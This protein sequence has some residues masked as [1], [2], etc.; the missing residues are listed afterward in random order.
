MLNKNFETQRKRAAQDESN[1]QEV[2]K[3]VDLMKDSVDRKIRGVF[4]Q[5]DNPMFKHISI[6]NAIQPAKGSYEDWL[7]LGTLPN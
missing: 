2:A 1:L 4:Y 3:E 6:L 7:E 5:F